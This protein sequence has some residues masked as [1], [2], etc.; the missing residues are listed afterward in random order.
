MEEE[1]KEK[2]ENGESGESDA[3]RDAGRDGA[4]PP[5]LPPDTS[6][7]APSPPESPPPEAAGKKAGFPLSRVRWLVQALFFVLFLWLLLGTEISTSVPEPRGGEAAGAAGDFDRVREPTGIPVDL[8]P[9]LSPLLASATMLAA[10]GL[11]GLFWPA[12]I[13]IALTVL[14][15]RFFCSWVCPLGTTID[16]TDKLFTRPRRK[17]G[18][19]AKP[20]LYDGRRAK[21]YLLAFLLALAFA[22]V[23][24]AGWFDPLAIVTRI[25]VTVFLPAL[26][27]VAFWIFGPSG[28]AGEWLATYVFEPNPPP[29]LGAVAMF[30]IFFGVVVLGGLVYRRYWCRNLCP[31]GALLALLGEYAPL[32]RRVSPGACIECGICDR[33]CRMDAI[34]AETEGRATLAGECI[35]CPDCLDVCPNSAVHFLPRRSGKAAGAGA[36]ADDAPP[37]PAVADI[38]VSLSRRGFLVGVGSGVL[39]APLLALD[40]AAGARSDARRKYL[41]RPPAAGNVHAGGA[42]EIIP[43]PEQMEQEFLV[44][45]V[46]CEQCVKVCP[47]GGLQPDWGLGGLA[48]LWAPRLVPR[49]GSCEY[50]CNLCSQVC[51]SG[52]IPKITREEKRQTVLGKSVFDTNRC[53]PWRPFAPF[54]AALAR[55]ESGETV[56]PDFPRGLPAGIAWTKKFD[57]GTCQEACT[58]VTHAI[59]FHRVVVNSDPDPDKHL[60][61]KLPYI[62]E[63]LCVGCG[64]CENVCPIPDESAIR[65]EAQPGRLDER[66]A[67]QYE[68]TPDIY[69]PDGARTPSPAD[70]P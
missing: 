27:A 1:Q 7:P 60:E 44:R 24:L 57:C 34:P 26:G 53:I 69:P 42:G 48:G 17:I 9:R 59:R 12:L 54:L 29:S 45:C 58:S 22:G 51:P 14:L 37:R 4:A 3:G 38:P 11:I 41:I 21:Y 62:I 23:N 55:V 65:V 25:Y 18:A 70:G 52:A 28:R 46:R 32:R 66:R 50:E 30:L 8:F 5:P 68:Q 56:P 63:D 36:S 6:P 13:L 47:S 67:K 64:K 33:E 40:S 35:L 19:E 15:G 43:L 2:T 10:R 61:A 49:I 39:A 31:L 20:R 16:L